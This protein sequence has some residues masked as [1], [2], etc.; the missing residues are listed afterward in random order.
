MSDPSVTA[1]ERRP[2]A[3]VICVQADRLDEANLKSLRAEVASAA[4]ES[5]ELPVIV[6]PVMVSEGL[7]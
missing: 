4:L 7:Q 2:E 3:L 6:L 5:P 1:V